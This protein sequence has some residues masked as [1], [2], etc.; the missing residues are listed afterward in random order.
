MM[1]ELIR[2]TLTL[3]NSAVYLLFCQAAWQAEKALSSEDNEKDSEP[4]REAHLDL[5]EAEFG[6]EVLTVLQERFDMISGNWKEGWTAAT[7]SM[8]A[9]RLFS[10]NADEK[11]KDGVQ[12]FLASLRETISGWMKQVLCLMKSEAAELTTEEIN[13]LRDRVI[14][15]AITCRSTYMLGDAIA[16]IFCDSNALTLFI[17]SAMVLQNIVPPNL[18]SLSVPL[19]YVAEKNIVLSAQVF[20]MLRAAVDSDN[21]G[22]DNAIR[23][24]TWQAFRRDTCVSWKPIGDRWM[25]CQTSSEGNA[26]VCHVYFNLH[27]GTF[28]VN[29]KRIGGLPKDILGHSLF[30]SLFPNQVRADVVA[31]GSFAI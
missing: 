16:G 27:D 2:G 22:L 23:C 14:Q 19:R 18:S 29:G 15:L 25:T 21:F 30:R 24:N 8:I 3:G 28:L 20:D 17:D 31:K 4:Y 9:C 11:V 26:R 6:Q 5:S 13:E 1:L 7:L 12:V 10:L